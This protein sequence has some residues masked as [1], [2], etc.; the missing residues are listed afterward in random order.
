MAT[1]VS[2]LNGLDLE[3]AN[4]GLEGASLDSLLEWSLDTFGDKVVQVTSF[5]P[6]GM[7]ILDHLA[8]VRPGARVITIDTH[9]LFA[10]SYELR[11]EI[12]RRYDV[13]LDVRST[14]VT[15]A[16][17]EHLY[18]ARL[19]ELEPDVCC[20]LRKVAPLDDALAGLS[21]WISGIRRDQSPARAHAALVEWDDRHE[22]LKLNLLAAWTRSHVWNYIHTHQIPYNRLHDEG[23]ASIGCVHC[24]RPALAVEDERTGRWRGRVKT[25]CGLH[26]SRRPVSRCLD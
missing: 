9:F 10:E 18:G 3:S 8:R 19:W 15:P 1:P 21:A 22:M 5:G 17:Q 24:T 11:A 12:E 25:E 13:Q 2:L 4:A 16:Q 14:V 7:V 23:Y 26:L 6:S 20:H